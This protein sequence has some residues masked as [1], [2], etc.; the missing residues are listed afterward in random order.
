[1]VVH[2]ADGRVPSCNS[3]DHPVHSATL[4][5]TQA[6]SF[7]LQDFN[8]P[9]L[10]FPGYTQ[11]GPLVESS[12]DRTEPVTSLADECP[13][14]QATATTFQ[15]PL[16]GPFGAPYYPDPFALSRVVQDPLHI[17]AVQSTTISPYSSSI[18]VQ[19]HAIHPSH[20][21]SSQFGDF[22]GDVAV[23]PSFLSPTISPVDEIPVN[24]PPNTTHI[25]RCS[26][27]CNAVLNGSIQAVR[28]HLKQEHQFHG[29]SKESIQCLWARCK[30]ILQREN[31]PRHILTRHLRVKVS[32][33]ACGAVLSRR[34]VQYSHARVCRARGQASSQPRTNMSSANA[35]PST[36]SGSNPF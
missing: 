25:C 2:L 18:V 32:C 9:A 4:D 8:D 12:V 19:H 30:Q 6:Q 1:M 28:I 23:A 34:D 17:D 14:G 35:H 7:A 16:P 11:R 3:I 24:P 13:S 10:S 20:Q 27:T 36:S 15:A 31:I 21:A 22:S 33:R 5:D 26:S 29:A